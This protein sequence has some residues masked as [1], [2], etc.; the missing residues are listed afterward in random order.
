MNNLL[1]EK[2][3]HDT[4][5]MQNMWT[6]QIFK[7]IKRRRKLCNSPQKQFADIVKWF[8]M[9]QG[10]PHAKC[11][12]GALKHCKPFTHVC[13][14]QLPWTLVVISIPVSNTSFFSPH[15]C[16]GTPMC[17]PCVGVEG[18]VALRGVGSRCMGKIGQHNYYT[19][20]GWVSARK[21]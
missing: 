13:R 9:F 5:G 16:W 1:H 17:L 12:R 14:P 3:N 6:L 15:H 10:T 11:M 2:H 18:E 8:A 20:H 4:Y 7:R 21:T 19:T